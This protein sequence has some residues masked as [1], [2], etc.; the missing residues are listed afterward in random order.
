MCRKSGFT[1]VELLVVIAIIALLIA[2]VAPAIGRS[3]DRARA[4]ECASNLRQ[5]GVAMISMSADYQGRLPPVRDMHGFGTHGRVWFARLGLH[6][7]GVDSSDPN[8][9]IQPLAL[10]GIFFCGTYRRIWNDPNLTHW[11][12]LGYGMNIRLI[13]GAAPTTEAFVPLSR[14]VDASSRV[15]LADDW[16][17]N[18]NVHANNIAGYIGIEHGLRR[19][20][21][22]NDAAN[23]LFVEGSV[24][25]IS[26]SAEEWNPYVP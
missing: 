3:M 26:A 15:L 6:M 13:E 19:G 8:Q 24:R 23:A 11:N 21:R 10:P 12:Q 16:A 22:H 9:S 2:L 4:V 5:L 17:W 7:K 18:W 1:L 20:R 14:I 25:S